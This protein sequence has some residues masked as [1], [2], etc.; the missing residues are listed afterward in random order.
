M[1]QNKISMPI[2]LQQEVLS[3]LHD[4]FLRDSQQD[5][6]VVQFISLFFWENLTRWVQHIAYTSTPF[7]IA[8]TGPSGSGK[9]FIRET[10]VDRLSQFTDVAAFTQD[11]YY[12]DFEADFHHLPLERFYDEINFDDPA[13]IRFKHLQRDLQQLRTQPVGSTLRIPR[14]RFGTPTRKPAIIEEDLALQI[15]PFIITEGIHA[16]YDPAVLPYYDLKIYVDVEETTRR[17]RWLTRNRLENRGTTDNMWQTTVDCL[18]QH[19]LPAQLAADL[20]INNNLPQEQVAYF[21][22]DVIQ[23]LAAVSPLNQRE[24]A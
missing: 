10:L 1:T 16:F 21:L 5:T 2:S 6:P 18:R 8:L 20:V 14:L 15:T 9:S 4:V 3:R 11:N 24:I 19:I 12:R 23:T 22:D 17:E 13:H 7:T